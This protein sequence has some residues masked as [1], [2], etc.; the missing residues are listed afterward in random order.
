[1][2]LIRGRVGA[3]ALFLPIRRR[4]KKKKTQSPRLSAARLQLAV[5]R[6]GLGPRDQ[7][8]QR[9]QCVSFVATYH[10]RVHTVAAA[11]AG[12]RAGVG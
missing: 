3:K 8:Q 4:I 12:H 10:T 6:R 5:G 2:Y 9:T 11:A 7:E 1:M